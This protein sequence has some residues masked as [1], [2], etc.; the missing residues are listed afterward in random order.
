MEGSFMWLRVHTTSDACLFF[1]KTK[2]ILESIAEVA[3]RNVRNSGWTQDTFSASRA[4][5]AQMKNGPNSLAKDFR[6]PFLQWSK[7]KTRWAGPKRFSLEFALFVDGT[8]SK[9]IPWSN[10]IASEANCWALNWR[11]VCTGFGR[12]LDLRAL[13]TF[14]RFCLRTSVS[15]KWAH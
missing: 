2:K 1:V 6:R 7:R 4:M 13:A 5:C 11:R 12:K 14:S 10:F 9:Q 3:C 8:K 15:S